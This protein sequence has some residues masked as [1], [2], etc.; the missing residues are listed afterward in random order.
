[1]SIHIITICFK[2]ENTQLGVSDVEVYPIMSSTPTAAFEKLIDMAI[3]QFDIDIGVGVDD[4][5]WK[6]FESSGKSRHFLITY[7][8]CDDC[9]VML[10]AE[11]KDSYLNA[12]NTLKS[13]FKKRS[14]RRI[15]N[16]DNTKIST[17]IQ[18]HR[19]EYLVLLEALTHPYS[20]SPW[21]KLEKM[22]AFQ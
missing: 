12:L 17:F 18:Q 11:V 19:K 3:H 4:K 9:Q 20:F 6:F 15:K 8:S 21:I 7:L 14:L 16:M 2:C 1:M 13:D 22:Y 10:P 5:Q